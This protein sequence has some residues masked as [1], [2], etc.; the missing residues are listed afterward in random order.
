MDMT[1][2][3]GIIRSSADA[4]DRRLMHGRIWLRGHATPFTELDYDGRNSNTCALK[5]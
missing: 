5:V 1:Q 4:P 2:P 3:G